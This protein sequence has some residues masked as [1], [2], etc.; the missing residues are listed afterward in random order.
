MKPAA[1]AAAGGCALFAAVAAA[2]GAEPAAVAR[3]ALLG[4]TL[5]AV[6]VIDLRE[7]RI[8]NAIVLPT[9]AACAALLVLERAAISPLVPGL[10]LVAVLAAIALAAPA[11]LGMGDVKLALLLAL[12]IG[13]AAVTALSAGFVL[14]A[15]YA[16]ALLARHGRSA[17]R[18]ALPLAPFL[19]TGALGALVIA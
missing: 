11:A 7:H 17:A 5:G 6:V 19:A 2:T 3:L 4:A 14:A 15:V 16:A 8:P 18:T 9:A 12:G 13:D 1:T 10:V